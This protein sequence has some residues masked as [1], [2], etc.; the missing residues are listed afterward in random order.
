MSDFNLDE[1]GKSLATI[2]VYLII[3]VSFIII[4]SEIINLTIFCYK[5]TYLYHYGK[6]NENLCKYDNETS[7][8]EY[9][10]SRYRIFSIINN[11]KLKNDLFNKNWINYFTYLIIILLTIIFFVAF[12]TLFYKFF[13]DKNKV[14]E[15][16]KDDSNASFLRLLIK[17]MFGKELSDYIPNCTLNYMIAFILLIMF[18]IIFIFK[19]LFKVDYTYTGGYWTRLLHYLFGFTLIYYI[20]LLITKKDETEGD[21][22]K[23]YSQAFI[24]TS[25]IIIFYFAQYVFMKVQEE[26]NNP[27]KVGKLY[28]NEDDKNDT[29]FFDIY[30]QQEPTKPIEPSILKDPDTKIL[31]TTFKYLNDV[32]FNNLNEDDKIKYKSNLKMIDT[33]YKEKKAYDEKFKIYNDKYNIYNN[34]KIKFPELIS[35]YNDLIPKIVGLDKSLII[36][37]IIMIVLFVFIYFLFR[38]YENHYCDYYYYTILIYLIGII[39]IIILSNAILTYNTYFN[40]F[41]I[42]EPITK[43]KY[44]LNNLNTIFNI[45]IIE[46]NTESQKIGEY[47]IKNTSNLRV[48]SSDFKPSNPSSGSLNYDTDEINNILNKTINVVDYSTIFNELTKLNYNDS[49]YNS[50]FPIRNALHIALFS[51]LLNRNDNKTYLTYSKFYNNYNI[52]T[53]TTLL[54]TSY[55]NISIANSLIST[56]LTKSQSPIYLLNTAAIIDATNNNITN[57]VLLFFEIIKGTSINNINNIDDKINQI[58]NNIKYL[59]YKNNILNPQT[60]TTKINDNKF[61]SDILM[62]DI[63]EKDLNDITNNEITT[64]KDLIDKYKNQLVYINIALDYYADFLKEARDLFIIFFNESLIKCD[65]SDTINFRLKIKEYF[66]KYTISNRILSGKTYKFNSQEKLIG[67][68]KQILKNKMN[69]FNVLFSKYFIVIKYIAYIGIKDDNDDDK[70]KL[71][72]IKEIINNYNIYNT[73]HDKYLEENNLIT[74]SLKVPSNYVNLYNNLTIKNKT[75]LELNINNVSWSF[76]IVV[77]IFAAILIEPTII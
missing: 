6:Q 42:Y 9:E 18:P 30:K 61:Y 35:I 44:D 4:I 22:N 62:Q 27:S 55:N 76:V 16:A 31:L 63:T 14:C 58:K 70:I 41:T 69:K 20:Y 50:F 12:G 32:E 34:N 43:Y 72:I 36:M 73:G 52:I 75:E 53:P 64:N 59:I 51:S 3:F 24:Y 38:Y 46:N 10:K 57:D 33:Y 29:M 60:I 25:F 8:L 54:S 71:S 39:S 56:Y 23:K 19:G 47:Y 77:I 68:I 65:T 67:V 37:I 17:C 26:Y 2:I 49:N 40:K 66:D 11:Y 15:A 1:Y 74:K 7:I 13:I 45:S 48:S 5:Y 21:K 28:D